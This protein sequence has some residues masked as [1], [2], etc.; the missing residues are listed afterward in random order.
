MIVKEKAKTKEGGGDP[1]LRWLPK[2][3]MARQAHAEA[4]AA[5]LTMDL[6]TFFAWRA[7]RSEAENRNLNWDKVKDPQPGDK[8]RSL[9]LASCKYPEYV[10]IQ[11]KRKE[12]GEA[13][14]QREVSKSEQKEEQ[15]WQRERV[16][17]EK[18]DW[19][20]EMA[21]DKAKAQATEIEE[22]AKAEEK[23]RLAVEA[24]A[25]QHGRNEK[26]GQ[27]EQRQERERLR[28]EE[29]QAMIRPGI[30][31]WTTITGKQEAM[32]SA[33]GGGGTRQGS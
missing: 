25:G 19:D 26:K 11:G 17:K 20:A 5:G 28:W 2:G 12:A 14:V 22:A 7:E 30:F 27:E 6:G 9:N 31:V 21:A 8:E 23:K 29:T 16:A 3:P 15:R 33:S 1:V 4:K 18:A 13:P 24:A 10:A 32:K